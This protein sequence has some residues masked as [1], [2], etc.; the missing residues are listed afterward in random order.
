MK[1]QYYARKEEVEGKQKYQLLVEHLNNV[2]ELCKEFVGQI[3]SSEVGEFLG[4][5]HDVGKYSQDF[6]RRIRG[7]N[8]RV[9]HATAGAKIAENLYQESRGR[10]P[11]YRLIAYAICGHHSGLSNYGNPTRGL[12]KRISG[13]VSDFSSW[14]QDISH[15]AALTLQHFKCITREET[16]GFMLQFYTRYIFSCLVD[17]DRIDAQNFLSDQASIAMGKQACLKTLKSKFDTHMRNLRKSS[18][19]SKINSIRN[20]ILDSCIQKALGRPG[21]YSLTVPTG[22]GKTL[23]SLAFALNHAIKNNQRRIIYTMPFTSIIE[24]NAEVFSKMLGEEN[25]LEHHSNFENPYSTEKEI[26]KFKLA[27]EN[28]HE[29]VIVTT[30]VQFFETLFSNKPTKVRKLHNIARSIIILD[31]IQSI[32]NKY[33]LPCLSALNELV[34]NYGCTIVLCSATQP[35]FEKNRL[36]LEPVRIHEIIEEPEK[37]FA[38]LKRTTE[39]FIGKQD[40]KSISDLIRQHEQ[41][42]CIVNTKKHARD[43]FKILPHEENNFHLS[44]NMYPAHRKMVIKKIRELLQQGKPCK[45]ISTQ[46]IEAGVDIDFPVVYRS[47]TGIDSMV[48]AAGR[49]NREGKLSTGNVYVFEPEEK[50][51]GKEYLALTAEIGKVIINKSNKFLDLNSIERYFSRLF[52]ATKQKL[53]AQDILKLCNQGI[54]EPTNIRF[55]FETI[56]ERFKFIDNQGYALVIQGNQEVVQLIESIKFTK[57]VGG[58][59]KRLSPYTINIKPYELERL[60]EIGAINIV[61]DNILV[62]SD[63]ELYDE[64]IGLGI[65]LQQDDF[66]YIV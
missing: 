2:S 54:E 36:F 8:I 9:D 12:C 28:W 25:V 29:P 22:G 3:S 63:I 7:E 33:I 40:V 62:L 46:L 56:S 43:I 4:L 6:Q 41:V 1:N 20:E 5:M 34:I 38:E 42:L 45:V 66:E 17:A 11:L 26:L 61:E 14:E 60:V 57:S 59:L 13:Q 35:G 19:D 31:E 37:L 58:V 16:L 15:P 51:I 10:N 52:D 48:Q 39:H 65:E 50:Y 44:T 32:P 24:Q 47:I 23:S 27:K 18:T 64:N 49:C 21:I 30:N 55:E 53:D